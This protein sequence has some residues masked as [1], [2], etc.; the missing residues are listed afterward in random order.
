MVTWWDMG[1]YGVGHRGM[2]RSD[3]AVM[4]SLRV[5]MPGGS[6]VKKSSAYAHPLL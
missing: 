5:G 2:Q 4:E 1:I 3:E 6:D